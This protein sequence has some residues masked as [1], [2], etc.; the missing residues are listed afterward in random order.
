MDLPRRILV[1]YALAGAAVA[2]AVAIIFVQREL[3]MLTAGWVMVLRDNVSRNIP[4]SDGGELMVHTVFRL[5]SAIRLGTGVA[6]GMA[7]ASLALGWQ[8][9]GS[10]WLASVGIALGALAVWVQWMW[11]Q[12]LR[13]S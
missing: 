1:S 4:K 9:G 3:E 5:I 10:R 2:L 13:W 7:V 11:W 6:V 8:R 12:H